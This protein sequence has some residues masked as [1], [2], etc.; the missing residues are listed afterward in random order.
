MKLAFCGR[1]GVGKSFLAEKAGKDKSDQVAIF[2][3]DFLLELLKIQ[4]KKE[5]LINLFGCTPFQDTR[6]S[7]WMPK[8]A[9]LAIYVKILAVLLS[10]LPIKYFDGSDRN[11]RERRKNSLGKSPRQLLEEIGT[12]GRSIHP[13]FWID[14]TF[15]NSNSG[16]IADVRYENEALAVKKAGYLLICLYNSDHEA[17]KVKADET[18]HDSVWSFTQFPE[19]YDGCLCNEVEFYDFNA[20]VVKRLSESSIYYEP[21]SDYA[22]TARKICKLSMPRNYLG[23]QLSPIRIKLFIDEVETRFST[24]PELLKTIILERVEKMKIFRN[25]FLILDEKKYVCAELCFVI[26]ASTTNFQ[27]C[28]ADILNAER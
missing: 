28:F 1:N 13:N 24:F 18:V 19:L 17:V 12:W 2:T 16:H 25:L 6:V 4:D 5:E 21:L 9:N 20:A 3:L 23:D 15:T 7:L 10:G 8:M 27:V 22:W 26:L 14:A 11:L